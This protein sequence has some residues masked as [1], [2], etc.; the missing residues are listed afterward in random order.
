MTF[1][2]LFLTAQVS[3]TA[4][5]GN[6]M[7]YFVII[8]ATT[9]LSM[10]VSGIMQRRVRQY[11]EMPINATGAEVAREMLRQNGITDVQV[12]SVPGHLTDHYN[13]VDKT[14]NL[15]E[16]VYH[17]NTVAAAAVAAHECGHAVQHQQAYA[18]LGFRSKM[19]PVVN[20]AS[21]LQNLLFFMGIGGFF[22]TESPLMIQIWIGCLA[23]TALFA[24]VTLPVEFDASRRALVWME[25]SGFTS[26][27]DHRY[28][29]NALFWAAMTYVVAAI[30][31][32]AQLAYWVM[33]LLG[34]RRS[35]D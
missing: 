6:M 17:M 11:S 25:R 4:P 21:Q 2:T 1:A 29:Q 3:G 7:I 31:A 13:P 35:E 18:W 27:V 12:V 19:V 16:T 5:Q 34:G 15:S 10:V 20:I 28:A 30:G 26:A 14:V 33:V 9:L 32:V 22:M 24:V 8:G 23:A